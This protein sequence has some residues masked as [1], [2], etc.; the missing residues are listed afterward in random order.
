MSF[1]HGALVLFGALIT[2]AIAGRAHAVPA[3]RSRVAVV[4]TSPNDK[5]LREASTR[6][7]AELS[8]AGFEVAEVD[9]VPG[10]PRAEVER[11]GGDS[12]SFATVAIARAGSGAFADV[13]ISDIV[14]GKT[15]VRRLSVRGERAGATV[16]AIRALE[17]LR[18][19]LLEL[20]TPADG[21]RTES[22]APPDVVRWVEPVM[23]GHRSPVPFAGL[24]ASVGVY[25]LHGFGGIGPA[26]GPA[27]RVA[28]GI[29]AQW[30]GR[31]S[32]A[33]PLIAPSVS[34]PGGQAS[35]TQYVSSLDIGWA[36]EARPIGAFAWAGA[37][38]SYLY[39]TGAAAPPFHSTS[40]GVLSFVGTVGVGG[41]VKLGRSFA[42]SADLAVLGLVPKPTVVIADSEAGTAGG[43]SLGASLALVIVL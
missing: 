13:W 11:A 10:D 34:A 14:T 5:L 22:A 30:F 23:P 17:L 15:V 25:G 29:G 32:L 36:T 28:H 3:H 6:L 31:F 19:S 1:R 40:A 41:L 20:A 39:T 26:L 38:A 33:A 4:R 16:L 27:F 35:V 12:R 7:R 24:A 18:A 21:S 43:P 8:A 42:L 9:G 37:G 2:C